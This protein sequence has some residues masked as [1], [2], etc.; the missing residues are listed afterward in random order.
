MAKIVDAPP[1]PETMTPAQLARRQRVIDAVLDLVSEGGIDDMQMRELA[2]RSG[3]A[4]GTVY[5]Y[6]SSKDHVVAAALLSWAAQLDQRITRRPLP[7]APAVERLKAVLH[8]GQ[9]AFQRAPN[10][11]RLMIT[12]ASSTDPFAS[13]SYDELG[14]IVGGTL[15]RAMPE[16]PS[17]ERDRVVSVVGAVWFVALNEWLNGRATVAEVYQRLD[18]VCDLVL[19]WREQV[20]TWPR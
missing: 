10:F 1:A 20:P 14:R 17:E 3:V 13:E 11:A 6:F 19:G 18:D 15:A 7:D 16:V 4:L 5:R 2:E 8:H 12:S 9:R